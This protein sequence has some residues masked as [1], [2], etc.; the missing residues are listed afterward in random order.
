[1]K[2]FMAGLPNLEAAGR[3][4]LLEG[5]LFFPR[6]GLREFAGQIGVLLMP[7]TVYAC[8]CSCARRVQSYT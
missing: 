3:M 8:I 5:S 4:T 7:F 2:A 6:H 1:M